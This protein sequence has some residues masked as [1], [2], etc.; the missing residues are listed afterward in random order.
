MVVHTYVKISNETGTA[1]VVL[2]AKAVRRR[3]CAVRAVHPCACVACVRGHGGRAEGRGGGGRAGGRGRAVGRSGGALRR[4]P[5]QRGPRGRRGAPGG[6]ASGPAGA[7][8][9][10]TPATRAATS[11]AQNRAK[12]RVWANGHGETWGRQVSAATSPQGWGHPHFGDVGREGAIAKDGKELVAGGREEG[13]GR[14]EEEKK[15]EEMEDEKRGEGG[16]GGCRPPS[17]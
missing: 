14:E 16:V 2:R 15:K 10:C 13:R 3:T 8:E 1:S 4:T 12:R 11:R 5:W 6:S 7:G 17:P 9:C